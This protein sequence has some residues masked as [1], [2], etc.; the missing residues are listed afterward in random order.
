MTVVSSQHLKSTP[1]Q[2]ISPTPTFRIPPDSV[3]INSDYIDHFIGLTER[4]SAYPGL[5]HVR[6]DLT[7]L[8][9]FYDHKLVPSLVAVRSGKP[10]LEHRLLGITE[11]DI[12]RVKRHVEEQILETSWSSLEDVGDFM[13]VDWRTRIHSILDM[14]GEALEDIWHIVNSTAVSGVQLPAD[15]Q[16]VKDAFRLIEALVR[17]FVLFSVSPHQDPDSGEKK[18]DI[19]WASSVFKEC[20]LSHT[21][22]DVPTTVRVSLPTKSEQLLSDAVKRTTRELCRVLTKIW[23]EGVNEGLSGLF[24][25]DA[26]PHSESNRAA[27]LNTWKDDIRNLMM[28]LDWGSWVRCKPA[29]KEL[30]STPLTG[31]T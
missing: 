26:P 22:P 4:F 8:V 3:P 23:A 5:K 27:L 18:F 29:C 7:H 16:R 30:V 9:S 24:S 13:R 20:V 19:A 1:I 12:L 31:M 2:N 21:N 17:R 11:E 15:T 6:L 10:R 25:G 14:Y 28:W